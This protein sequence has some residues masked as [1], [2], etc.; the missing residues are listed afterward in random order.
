[1]ASQ[2]ITDLMT[3]LQGFNNGLKS[4]QT[5][6][7]LN[8]ANEAVEQIRAS[9]ADAQ[10]KKAQIRGIA[11]QL[12]MKLVGLGGSVEEASKLGD[13]FKGPKAPTLQSADQA[14]LYGMQTGDETA[15]KGGLSIKQLELEARIASEERADK[16]WADRFEANQAEINKR[17]DKNLEYKSDQSTKA[18]KSNA[19]K[20]ITGSKD[21][22]NYQEV[23]SKLSQIEE[24]A[25]N[26]SAFGDIASVFGFMKSIDPESVV[27]ESE[28]AT[29]QE[30]GSLFTRAK[31]LVQKQVSGERLSDDQRQDLV[32]ISKHMESVFRKNYEVFVDP[33]RRQA[34]DRDVLIE[35]IDP[36]F[37]L[38]GRA[39]PKTTNPDLQESPQ[40]KTSGVPSTSGTSPK[41]WATRRN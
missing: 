11:D 34:V 14:I 33:W 2:G 38:S 29:A 41:N 5:S 4:L 22:K 6:R 7:V 17:A 26:P 35:D 24:F 32:R 31:N 19:T 21:F 37:N 15:L 13:L 30:A 16:R 25:K 36:L 40:P 39:S 27:R 18:F 23:Q 28:F 20:A 3:A 12:T 10:E 8:N 1:M 9:D